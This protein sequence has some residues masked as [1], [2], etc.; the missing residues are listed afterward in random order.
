MFE[1]GT[2]LS[3]FRHCLKSGDR[4]VL[5]LALYCTVCCNSFL[6]KITLLIFRAS[7]LQTSWHY[8]VCPEENECANGHDNCDSVSE[9]C[10]DKDIGFGCDCNVGYEM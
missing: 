4:F 3:Q 9:V 10:I 8:L 2:L 7:L 1:I 6:I 5:D